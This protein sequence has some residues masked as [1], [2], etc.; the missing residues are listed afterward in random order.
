MTIVIGVGNEFRRDDGAGPA[1]VEALRGRVGVTLAVTDGEPARL[2]ELWAGADL[3]IVVDAVRCDPP[4]PGRVHE[5]GLDTAAL[6]APPVTGHSLGLGDAVALGAAVGRMPR[7]LEVLAIE[8][9]EFGFGRGLT[10]RVAAAVDSLTRR[11]T[12]RLAPRPASLCGPHE[13]GRPVP[14]TSD[15]TDAPGRK[16]DA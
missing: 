9:S 4:S 1:A 15:G 11:L 5:L 8:G 12:A 14:A 10:P 16:D 6:A 3:A 2:I 7:V 13:P